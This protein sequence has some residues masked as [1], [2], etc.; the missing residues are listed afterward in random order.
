MKTLELISLEHRRGIEE[1]VREEK[2]AE[3]IHILCEGEAN[4]VKLENKL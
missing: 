2:I 3:S 4:Q 1:D